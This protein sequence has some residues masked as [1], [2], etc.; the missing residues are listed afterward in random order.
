[1]QVRAHVGGSLGIVADIYTFVEQVTPRAT[2]WKL[3]EELRFTCS[4]DANLQSVAAWYFVG[5][6]VVCVS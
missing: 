3:H 6:D 2:K 1:M 4:S 5:G